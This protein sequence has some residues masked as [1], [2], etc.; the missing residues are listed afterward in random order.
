[1]GLPMLLS[2]IITPLS[3]LLVSKLVTTV[4]QQG[5]CSFGSGLVIAQNTSFF[6]NHRSTPVSA[7]LPARWA[8][9]AQ[10]TSV[11]NGGLGGIYWKANED[12]SFCAC[13]DDV[14][15]QWDCVDQ[16]ADATYSAGT[17][18][19]TIYN[20]LFSKDLQYVDGVDSYWAQPHGVQVGMVIWSA[21]VGDNVQQPWDV[22]ISANTQL[23]PNEAINMKSFHCSMSSIFIPW[24]LSYINSQSA[25]KEWGQTLF[26][27]LGGY[28]GD[29]DGDMSG[30]MEMVLNS[31][32]MVSGS[33]NGANHTESE[34][35]ST[36]QGCLVSM[37]QLS[38]PVTVMVGITGLLFLLLLTYLVCLRVAAQPGTREE[39]PDGVLGWQLQAVREAFKDEGIDAGQ[40]VRKPLLESMNYLA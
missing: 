31:M 23:N 25:L 36:T 15:G 39:L 34:A 29:R 14:A 3:H 8:A 27:N 38:L 19:N 13:P 11:R 21:S 20:D 35:K 28:V 7:W 9:D 32:V 2:T 40:A 37:A 30:K 26:G 12:S 5:Q 16:M 18:F 22:K 1:M 33:G 10:S 17:D 4:Y 24:M 6:S